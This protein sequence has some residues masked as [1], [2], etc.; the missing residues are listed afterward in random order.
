MPWF[1][2][3]SGEITPRRMEE[4]IDRT[5]EEARRRICPRPKRVLLLPPDVTRAHS[6]AGRLTEQLY[7]RFCGEKIFFIPTPSAGLWATWEKLLGRE[8]RAYETG[9]LGEKT[10]AVSH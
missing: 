4:L 9:R 10:L 8:K 7:E 1:S 5:V 2:E 3:R 6:G